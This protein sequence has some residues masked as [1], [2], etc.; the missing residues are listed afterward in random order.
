M[1]DRR[2]GFVGT[3][4]SERPS[5]RQ[6]PRPSGFWASNHESGPPL[7]QEARPGVLGPG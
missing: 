7:E 4:R 6:S 2:S 5:S 3:S 1:T